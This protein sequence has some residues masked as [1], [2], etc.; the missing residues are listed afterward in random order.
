MDALLI[1]LNPESILKRGYS[2]TRTLPQKRILTDASGFSPGQRIEI[3]LAK[4]R[5][6]AE[7]R[8]VATGKG[9]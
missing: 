3:Q 2:I 6:E 4:G 1:A 5:I 9:R 8:N 7:V